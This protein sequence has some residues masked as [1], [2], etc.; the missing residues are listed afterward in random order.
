MMA[1]YLR[2][3]LQC[4]FLHTLLVGCAANLVMASYCILFGPEEEKIN[5]VL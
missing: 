5:F 4:V 3:E 1:A 2:A